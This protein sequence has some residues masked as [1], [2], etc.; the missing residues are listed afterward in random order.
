MVGRLQHVRYRQV[1]CTPLVCSDSHKQSE[2]TASYLRNKLF[3]VRS[4]VPNEREARGALDRET[5][6]S[7]AE[8]GDGS[9][10]RAAAC[11]GAA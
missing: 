2:C 3:R 11:L 9:G 5:G 4:R 10:V 7:E 8:A 6:Q 1:L